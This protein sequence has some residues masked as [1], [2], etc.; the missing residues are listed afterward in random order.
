[1]EINYVYK[2]TLTYD[3]LTA[4]SFEQFY[5]RLKLA[6]PS[7]KK[8][9]IVSD[10]N[11]WN[12]YK[13]NFSEAILKDYT[14]INYI[15]KAGEASKNID[16][17]L[18]LE[19]FLIAN[20]FSRNDALISVGG[21]V[22]SDFTGFAASLYKRGIPYVNIPTTLLSMVDASIGG[23]TAVDYAGIKNVIGAFKMPNL[24]Y[25]NTSVLKSL[26]DRDYFSGFAE[27]MKHGLLYDV[28]Y[29]EWLIENM[30]EICEKDTETITQMIERSIEIK[31]IIVTKDPFEKGDRALL[32]LGHTIGH[33][34]ESYYKGEYMHGECVALGTVAAAYISW[35]MNMISME[36][37]YEV[38]DMFVPFNLP[39]SIT[40]E[41]PKLLI[42][43]LMKDKKNVND[44]INMVLLKKLGKAV[45]VEDISKDLV[46]E[47]IDSLIFKEED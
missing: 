26:P 6:V 33:A 10:E 18:K 20:N 30:Y 21:G 45:L 27:V 13:D 25:I 4:D 37:Y 40:L 2:D 41:D 35:K 36:D 16:N 15:I 42:D 44:S 19:E 11:V 5:E 1:M 22:C 29:Y 46:I 24:V 14:V 31:K 3:I 28:K 39:I 17:V 7:A 34:I 43:I 12:I 47:A 23:K 8:L 38:R 32:N 9:C